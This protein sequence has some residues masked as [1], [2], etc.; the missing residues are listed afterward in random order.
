RRHVHA[1]IPP[2]T[3]WVT[4]LTG[5][6]ATL[7]QLTNERRHPAGTCQV[8]SLRESRLWQSKSARSVRGGGHLLGLLGLPDEVEVAVG[9]D[10]VEA[11]VLGRVRRAGQDLRVGR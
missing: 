5:S 10:L 9:A 1:S 7:H 4:S 8:A 2:G 11:L 6:P 3:A